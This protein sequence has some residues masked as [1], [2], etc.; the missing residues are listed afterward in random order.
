MNYGLDNIYNFEFGMESCNISSPIVTPSNKLQMNMTNLPPVKKIVMD[1]EEKSRGG[2]S[3]LP[4]PVLQ[5][6]CQNTNTSAG[7]NTAP[8]VVTNQATFKQFWS[9]VRIRRV[10]TE[11]QVCP[12]LKTEKVIIYSNQR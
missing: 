11:G 3:S 12:I 1:H 2:N 4:V 10:S 8:E 9:P 5:N 7:Q 6:V